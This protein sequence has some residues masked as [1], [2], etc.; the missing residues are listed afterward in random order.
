MSPADAIARLADGGHLREDEA[1]ALFVT[2]LQGELTPAQL[3]AITLGLRQKGE[4]VAEL[5]GAARA[6]RDHAVVLPDA[7]PNTIDTCGT[8]GDGAGTLNISTAAGLV[9]AG[10][11]VPVAKHGGRAASGRVGA[12]DVL[13][14]LGVELVLP[15][16]VLAAC[17]REVGFTFLFAPHFHPALRHVAGVRRELGI[18]T[19]FN[20][21]GPLVNPAGVRRQVI[22]VAQRRWVEPI[23]EVLR[24]L[25]TDHAWVVHGGVG[26]DEL[27]LEGESL[28]A[29]VVGDDLRL[30]TIDAAGAGLAPAPIAALQVSTRAEAA[31]ALRAVLQGTPGPA[32]DVV[33]LNAG[34]ALVVGGRAPD[35][36]AGVELATRAIDDGSAR[37][38]LD[39]LVAFTRAAAADAGPSPAEASR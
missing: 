6:L 38:V 19:V 1:Y 30:R 39:D 17:L 24:A 5:V 16:D 14:E 15:P 13:E 10:A 32:R 7:P 23:A 4:H 22:G 2:V 28:V 36:R 34:A 25:G 27:A 31:A 21:L 20:L 29:E 33:R 3:G 18:R 12:A 26:L 35:L 8:G 9:A 37:R 11:G